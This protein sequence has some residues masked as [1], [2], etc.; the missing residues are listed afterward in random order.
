MNVVVKGSEVSF[1]NDTFFN[2]VFGKNGFTS[3]KVEGDEKTPLGL[4]AIEKIYF[5]SDRVQ[6]FVS[7]YNLIPINKDDG[8]CDDVN[9]EYYNQ[10]IKL[11]F[12]E[13]H[14]ELW[15]EDELYDIIVVLDYNT[16]PVTKGKGSAIFMHVAKE[17]M[18]YTKGCIA[19]KK[20]DLIALL[21]ML[22]STDIK[23]EIRA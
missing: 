14:E 2:C 6:S 19:M 15:R 10:F 21:G 1:N 18:Q 11:P 9:S 3:G 12:G 8:W 5:R 4:F 23:V 7:I 17:N 20:Q 22:D 13:S 16:N